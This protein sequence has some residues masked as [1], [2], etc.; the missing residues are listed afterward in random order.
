MGSVKDIK[1]TYK[2]CPS[3]LVKKKKLQC[4]K[5][6]GKSDNTYKRFFIY[7]Q[8]SLMISTQAGV[9]QNSYHFLR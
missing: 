7:K 2:E 3:S 9:N 4:D 5:R 1:V 8:R 6:L